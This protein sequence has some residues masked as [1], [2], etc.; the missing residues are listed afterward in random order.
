MHLEKSRS[1]KI[2]EYGELNLKIGDAGE[3]YNFGGIAEG[4]FHAKYVCKRAQEL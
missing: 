2:V 3:S 1:R 4:D